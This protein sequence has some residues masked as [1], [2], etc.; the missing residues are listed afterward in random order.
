MKVTKD[1]IIDEAIAIL[2][3]KGDDPQK[4]D[5]KR[6]CRQTWHR[7]RSGQ[8]SFRLQRS[9]CQPLCEED[10]N[11]HCRRVSQGSHVSCLYETQGKTQLSVSYDL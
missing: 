11:V 7:S 3:E 4:V 8:L 2:E 9:A 1:A 5:Y 6:T 10:D